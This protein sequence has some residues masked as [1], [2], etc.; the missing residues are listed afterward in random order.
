VNTYICSTLLYS[1]LLFLPTINP[2]GALPSSVLVKLTNLIDLLPKEGIA[3][4][5]IRII[6]SYTTCSFSQ[7]FTK[8]LAHD[9]PFSFMLP[10][11]HSV[12]FCLLVTAVYVIHLWLPDLTPGHGVTSTPSVWCH[13]YI[14]HPSSSLSSSD[15]VGSLRRC[16]YSMMITN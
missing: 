11:F 9:V 3:T 4:V 6:R 8:F 10:F 5:R 14:S 1:S 7:F 16:W 15:S 12:F 2:R 13:P